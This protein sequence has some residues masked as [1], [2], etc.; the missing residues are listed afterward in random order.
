MISIQQ[1][2][3]VFQTNTATIQAV[4]DSL[5][6]EGAASEYV[7]IIAARAE[8]KDDE[9]LNKL[10]EVLQSEEIQNFIT[11]KYNGEVVAVGKSEE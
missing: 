10:V 11:E 6:V 4:D 8:D 3:K 2:S 1:L 9:K 7:N 5:F